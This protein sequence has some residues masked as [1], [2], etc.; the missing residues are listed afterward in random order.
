MAFMEIDGNQLRA[1]RGMLDWSRE[2]CAAASGVSME[3][4]KNIETGVF[5]PRHDTMQKLMAVFVSNNIGFVEGGV[6][7][8]AS[9]CPHCGGNL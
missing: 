1:A 3:T 5:K 2:Q 9:R 8:R 4:I 6:C 7:R